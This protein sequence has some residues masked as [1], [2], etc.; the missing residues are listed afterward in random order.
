MMKRLDSTRSVL[1]QITA[2]LTL[3]ATTPAQDQGG[4]PA[5]AL[6]PVPHPRH[7][8]E[9]KDGSPYVVPLGKTLVVMAVG[10][11]QARGQ[12]NPVAALTIDGSMEVTVDNLE[13]GL[14]MQPLS[15]SVRATEGQ[16]VAV[17]GSTGQQQNVGRAWCY[18]VQNGVKP[19]PLEIPPPTEWVTINQQQGFVVPQGKLLVL[20][21][22][23]S[24]GGES[25]TVKIN[26][27]PVMDTSPPWP[28]HPRVSPRVLPAGL[29]GRPG[30]TVTVEDSIAPTNEA[31]LHGYLVDV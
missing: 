21:S 5:T 22:G 12:Q 14:S 25:V 6:I 19:R 31:R 20:A 7:W 2:I 1:M 29:V 13:Y 30:E 8:I 4:F 26:G 10:V 28:I 3:V 17:G 16:T 23:G 24:Q 9:I 18:V 15:L 11:S 27:T